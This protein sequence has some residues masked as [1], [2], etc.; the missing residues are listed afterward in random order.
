MT[1]SPRPYR[2]H[3]NK[4]RGREQKKASKQ[5]EL[6]GSIIEVNEDFLPSNNRRGSYNKQYPVL[7]II[8]R[9]YYSILKLYLKMQVSYAVGDEIDIDSIP[10][11]LIRRLHANEW[12]P[13]LRKRIEDKI[14]IMCKKREKIFVDFFNNA[15][16]VTTKLHQL[17]LLPGIGPKRMW[18]II[19]IRKMTLFTS[20]ADI[21]E[22]T[23]LVPITMIVSRILEELETDQKYPLFTRK[24]LPAFH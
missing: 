4:H 10:T 6:I 2:D 12:T 18:D 16:P 3:T 23:G 13:E 11:L 1:D 21:E 5:R 22:R 20:F 8:G 9:E 17:R 15:K 24:N 14:T 19:E 7:I